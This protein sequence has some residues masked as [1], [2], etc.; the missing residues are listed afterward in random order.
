MGAMGRR[1]AKLLNSSVAPWPSFSQDEISTVTDVLQ[2]GRVNYWTGEIGRQF[3]REFAAWTGT[4]RAIALANGTLALDVALKALGIGPG[5]DVIVT[6]RTF[7]ASVSSVVGAGARPVF[8][9]VDYESGNLTAKTIAA[10][11]TPTTRAFVPV[12]LGGWPCDMTSIMDLARAHDC[13]VIE[14]CAQAH[15]A[16]HAG[17]KVGSFGDVGAWSF[18]QDKI[19]STGGEGGMVTTDNEDLW[20]TMWSYKDHGKSWEAVYE[21]EHP[22]GFRWIHDSFGT[23]WRMLEV[24]AA[25]GRAQ[26]AKMDLWTA[27]RIANAGQL[28]AALKAFPAAVRVPTI[29][30]DRD[31]HGFYRLYGYVRPD[32][33]RAT[34]DR[35]RIVQAIN[36]LGIP[37]FQG[38][39]SE[40]YHERA[41]DGTGLRPNRPLQVAQ[42]LG[43]TSLAFL[44]HPTLSADD[45]ERTVA[46][47]Q[48]VFSQATR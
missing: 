34:W 47:I 6:P 46:A 25:I 48:L 43:A 36:Q 7:I 11:I 33:L 23:N 30:E 39:C 31:K 9:D 29:S 10:A 44:V 16:W 20:N 3:E 5:D 4:R 17:R 19:M 38:S 12:H 42:E 45:V 14:D 24:Q 26:L 22:Q 21:R 2:S 15:G 27:Q 18:C 8:A 32:G 35:D 28:I 13:V 40:V 37:A 41:F 1:S